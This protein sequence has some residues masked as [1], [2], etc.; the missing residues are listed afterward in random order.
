MSDPWQIVAEGP[1][2][3]ASN[4][5]ARVMT[6][7][8]DATIIQRRAI[9]GIPSKSACEVLLPQINGFAGELLANLEMPAEEAVQRLIAIA[10][11]VSPQKPKHVNWLVVSVGD[12]HVYA[13]GSEVLV[14][15]KHLTP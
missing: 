12:V 5:A 9:K 1:V 7:E 10:G 3:C 2:R 4:G 6:D 11:T 14:T 8:P 13:D 15:R